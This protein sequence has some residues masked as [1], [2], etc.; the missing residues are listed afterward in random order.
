VHLETPDAASE[1]SKLDFWMS[2]L[3]T[4]KKDVPS[5]ARISKGY[6]EE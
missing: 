4:Q 5:L 3:S 6:G 2:N 1:A